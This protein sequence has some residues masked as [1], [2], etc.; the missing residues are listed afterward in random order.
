MY[1]E[2]G[3]GCIIIRVLSSI[4]NS[5]GIS[6]DISKKEILIDKKNAIKYK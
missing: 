4:K 5:N 1:L 3:S 2:D 6:G